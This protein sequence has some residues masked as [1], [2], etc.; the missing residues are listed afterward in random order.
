MGPSFHAIDTRYAVT[1]NPH[2][3]PIVSE[4]IGIG[5][6][7]ERRRVASASPL[8]GPENGVCPRPSAMGSSGEPR[9][10]GEGA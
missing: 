1:A 3:R 4:Q 5:V 8:T 10:K 6:L 7:Y 9:H 2:H